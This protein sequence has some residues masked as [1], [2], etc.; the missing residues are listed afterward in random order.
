MTSKKIIWQDKKR[1]IFGLPLSFTTYT[2]TEDKLLINFGIFS[3]HE[4]EVRLYRMTDFSVTQTLLQRIFK[5]GNVNISSSDNMQGNFS[6]I[7]IKKPYEV[8][9]ILSNAVEYERAG[10]SMS[11][12]EFLR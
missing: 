8:K 7:S 9:E 10:K 4:E 1:P 6:L 11:V 2:L 3:R 5:V 12:N